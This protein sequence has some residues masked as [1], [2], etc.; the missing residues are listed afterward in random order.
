MITIREGVPFWSLPG[1]SQGQRMVFD[2]GFKHTD[3][4]DSKAPCRPLG[5]LEGSQ[6]VQ[7]P[8]ISIWLWLNDG[9]VDGN[10][11]SLFQVPGRDS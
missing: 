8:F 2:D 5:R 11:H 10:R 6:D 4:A 3:Y 1:G 7:K 9:R